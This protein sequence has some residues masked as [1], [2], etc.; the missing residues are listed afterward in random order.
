[1]DKRTLYASLGLFL[2][3]FLLTVRTVNVGFLLDDHYQI[4]G[5]PAVKE[6]RLHDLFTKGYWE[7]ASEGGYQF[8]EGGDLYRPLTSLSVALSYQL[9]GEEPAGYHVEN[10]V[11][12][13]VT[14]VLVFWLIVTY[15]FSFLTALL[16]GA[17]FAVAP[18]HIEA[19]A[20]IILRN[21]MLAATFGLTYLILHARSRIYLALPFLV[22][23]T[24]CKENA[25]ALP[26]IAYVADH[27]RIRPEGMVRRILPSVVAA[28]SY[29]CLRQAI[30]GQLTLSESAYFPP[31]DSWP[32]VWLTMARFGFEQYVSASFLG[33]PLIFDF[34]RE[35]YPTS[36]PQDGVAWLCLALWILLGA[37]AL[38]FT[39]KKRSVPAFA[40]L[41]FFFLIG[42]TANVVTR[43]GVI[44]ALRLMYL[45]YLGFALLLAYPL[46]RLAE[47]A[48]SQAGRTL[49]L[50]FSGLLIGAY[51]VRTYTKLAVWEHALT[52]YEDVTEQAPRNALA[53]VHLASTQFNIA[54]RALDPPRDREEV[55]P[56]QW[57]ARSVEHLQKA[58]EVW[59]IYWKTIGR[60]LIRSATFSAREKQLLTILDQSLR[61][62]EVVRF[63]G[64][65][66]D[67]E[68]E[69][70]S[71]LRPEQVR[72]L[73]AWAADLEQ[74]RTKVA[75]LAQLAS[76]NPRSEPLTAELIYLHAQTLP[77]LLYVRSCYPRMQSLASRQQS[78]D[79]RERQELERLG[80]SMAAA[81][82]TLRRKVQQ[83]LRAHPVPFV[84]ALVKHHYGDAYLAMCR[85]NLGSLRQ[86][87]F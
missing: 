70:Q 42:P 49:V 1:M 67:L 45:P 31:E 34:Y 9:Y 81:L 78:L 52:F 21:E 63:R 57:H 56:G 22:A 69:S 62:A 33:T 8:L 5:N 85:Q 3:A 6:L 12:H 38:Y 17:L 64:A 43:I 76:A 2:L 10:A 55:K 36:G 46:G 29:L 86:Q 80:K 82:E 54:E 60:Q 72:E 19:V 4:Q 44:G 47:R 61:A 40:L 73:S 30:L 11:L 77:E 23:A 59:P 66:P 71:P 65:L 68:S 37:Y 41:L 24:L 15:G 39:F 26:A 75:V 79:P 7:N 51:A 18:V 27:V 50:T 25:I 83:S 14:C 16:T 53:Q 20:N 87:G 35:A 84:R 58:L 32:V 28:L 13:A 48:R 74:V